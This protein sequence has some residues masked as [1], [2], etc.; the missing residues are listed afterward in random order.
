MKITRKITLPKGG[1]TLGEVYDVKQFKKL[2]DIILNENYSLGIFKDNIVV[3][4]NFISAESIALD[5]DQDFTLKQAKEQFKDYK[6]IIATTKSHQKLKNGIKCDRFRVIIFLNEPIRDNET[7]FTTWKSIEKQFPKL[8]VQCKNSSRFFYP[9]L[10]IVSVNKSGKL[11]DVVKND[12]DLALGKK[13]APKILQLK[14]HGK[15]SKKTK[16]ALRKGLEPGSRN[17][18][19]FKIAKDFQENGF[20]EDEA[21]TYIT[22]A[23]QETET[24]AY[25]FTEFEVE[26]TIR[27]A[28]ASDPTNEPRKPFKLI[29]IKELY[30]IESKLEWV[31]ENLL[32]KGGVS[33]LSAVP[34]AGKSQIARQLMVAIATG[35]KF[36][37]RNTVKGEV[38]YYAIEE[39]AEIVNDAFKKLGLP[40]DSNLFVHVGEVFSENRLKDLHQVLK[41]RKPLLIVID[42]LFD[43]IDV[44]NENNYKDVKKELRNLRH[45][46]RDTDTH[47]VCVHH[48]NKATQGITGNHRG[49]LGSQAIVGG[50]D[51]II[52]IELNGDMRVITTMGRSIKKWT[53]RELVWD[54]DKETYSLGSKVEIDQY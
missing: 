34:K 25:D 1:S 20:T 18:E 12:L 52:L 24:L 28:Y 35:G 22:K 48:S 5:F 46:A 44:E 7:F 19:T 15:L 3:K 17:G 47:I 40:P 37:G 54:D 53:T 9:S 2:E 11:F 6:H 8:D 30:K 16:T 33:L 27:S 41:E 23:F 21:V 50:V 31:V 13:E 45:I 42:T 14:G 36:L 39:Q 29:P 26:N 38:H 4:S 49:V 43:V 10:Q 32:S 51:V